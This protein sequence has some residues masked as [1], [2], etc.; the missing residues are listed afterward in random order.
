MARPVRVTVGAVAASNVIPLNNLSGSPF[1]V[2]LFADLSA[3]GSATYSV[4]YTYN[5]VFADSF[6]AAGATWTAVSGMSGAIAD[7][8]GSLTA[9]VVAVRLNVTVWAS[10]T[11]TLTIVQQN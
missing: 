2:G 8:S 11:V 7:S 9:P 4:E 10:G 6:T 1:N 5:D 3:G